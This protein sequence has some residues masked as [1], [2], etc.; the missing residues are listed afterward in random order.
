MHT[1]FY[2]K[3]FF[4]LANQALKAGKEVLA[5][6]YFG[7]SVYDQR[8]ADLDKAKASLHL[9]RY[10]ID[11]MTSDMNANKTVIK[12]DVDMAREHFQNAVKFCSDAM[13][14]ANTAQK[15]LDEC[16]DN[17]YPK[18]TIHPL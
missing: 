13:E 15:M 8:V 1:R 18:P 5:F 3:N 16:K 4:Q 17:S 14:T 6:Q 12:R 11:K 10:Y 2:S 7:Y 9:G